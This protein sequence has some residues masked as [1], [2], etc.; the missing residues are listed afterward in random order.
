MSLLT[1]CVCGRP[2]DAEYPQL[3]S[4]CEYHWVDCR[5]VPL[6]IEEA[7]ADFIDNYRDALRKLG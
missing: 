2:F 7:T 4:E 5:C 6:L 1:E 3:C